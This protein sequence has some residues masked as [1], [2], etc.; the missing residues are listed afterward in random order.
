MS[1][2]E[3]LAEYHYCCKTVQKKDSQ[4]SELK[5]FS[6]MCAV[7]QSIISNAGARCMQ[8]KY[9]WP[10]LSK[11]VFLVSISALLLPISILQSVSV[12]NI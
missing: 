11:M 1:L 5:L 10:I 7:L 3:L 8:C 4:V 6:V 2:N 9:I 12:M